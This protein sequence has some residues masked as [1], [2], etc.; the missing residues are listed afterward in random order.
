MCRA[1]TEFEIVQNPALGAYA[2]WRFG[3]RFQSGDVRPAALPLVFLVLPLLLHQPTLK[4]IGS[5]LKASGLTLFAA[6][7]AQERE[8]LAVHERALVLRRLSLQSLA[9]GI[10]NRLLTLDY[11]AATMRA[12]TAETPP[13]RI[14][15]FLIAFAASRAGRRRSGIGFP[16]RSVPWLIGPPTRSRR[17]T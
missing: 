4:L 16:A 6:K 11:S 7:L 9:M 15:P 1:L 12:N 17:S 14:R 8:N 5:T 3:V 10:D 2:L 13:G